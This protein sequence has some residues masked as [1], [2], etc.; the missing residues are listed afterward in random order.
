M[1]KN[2]GE[3]GE[4]DDESEVE[5]LV[6]GVDWERN[7]HGEN[8]SSTS[9]ERELVE[10]HVEARTEGVHWDEC[11]VEV[12]VEGVDWECNIHG[13]KSSSTSEERELVEVHIDAVVHGIDWEVETTG[14]R[15]A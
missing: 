9:E 3:E 6:E 1:S 4:T 10:V 13:E 11:E 14:N 5:V 2:K 12:L 15:L 8:S 7:I